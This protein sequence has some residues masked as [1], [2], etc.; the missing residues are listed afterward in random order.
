MYKYGFLCG[1]LEVDFFASVR[2]PSASTTLRYNSCNGDVTDVTP[3]TPLSCDGVT[4]LLQQ[5]PTAAGNPVQFPRNSR[6]WTEERMSSS[7]FTRNDSWS[8]FSSLHSLPEPF[9]CR[10]RDDP[11]SRGVLDSSREILDTSLGNADV[12]RWHKGYGDGG[13]R[14]VPRLI[15]GHA[16]VEQPPVTNR[17][18]NTH[19]R[20]SNGFATSYSSGRS[21][22]SGTLRASSVGHEI[23]AVCF[24]DES[25]LDSDKTP[26]SSLS[27]SHK[28]GPVRAS[29]ARPGNVVLGQLMRAKSVT[30]KTLRKLGPKLSG[31][32]TKSDGNREPG[33]LVVKNAIMRRSSSIAQRFRA[34]RQQ[35]A[36]SNQ[37][38]GVDR[39]D[40][41]MLSLQRRG[42]R[43]RSPLA[44]ETDTGLIPNSSHSAFAAVSKMDSVNGRE[45][46]RQVICGTSALKDGRKTPQSAVARL[47]FHGRDRTTSC[48]IETTSGCDV[49]PAV[50]PRSTEP[51][52]RTVLIEPTSYQINAS[53]PIEIEP[54]RLATDGSSSF[55]L[56]PNYNSGRNV[57][58][59][60]ATRSP[61]M[62]SPESSSLS[63][64][65]PASVFSARLPP[66]GNLQRSTGT[67]N[68]A[69]PSSPT[70]DSAPSM[71]ELSL[72]EMPRLD[73]DLIDP[74]FLGLGCRSEP[75]MVPVTTPS[76]APVP[77]VSEQAELLRPSVR[78]IN[79]TVAPDLDKTC[80]SLYDDVAECSPSGSAHEHPVSGNYFELPLETVSGRGTAAAAE[81]VC[82]SSEEPRMSGCTTSSSPNSGNPVQAAEDLKCPTVSPLD[83]AGSSQNAAVLNS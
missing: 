62:A 20:P 5:Q 28:A 9:L 56:R 33:S 23:D 55:V 34:F 72:W 76:P 26:T 21:N 12:G 48:G 30:S 45:P 40:G 3:V 69:L 46:A 24:G 79:D 52:S 10:N 70:L 41:G 57:R 27:R 6:Q 64:G 50:R 15:N 22:D 49:V 1:F 14:L 19:G 60:P 81:N 47:S 71:S 73:I 74:V 42:T 66:S 35:S 68:P 77:L 51:A 53:N 25:Q 7:L 54:R 44:Y 18:R 83:E 17:V 80:C 32:T 75:D 59:V 16:S 39:K 13:H 31:S 65:S 4:F 78:A 36:E 82:K 58:T 8:S 29:S 38:A 43:E 37:G 11:A 2:H 63:S 67:S 61:R